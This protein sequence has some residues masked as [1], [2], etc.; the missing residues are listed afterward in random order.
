MSFTE[1]YNW[2]SMEV[3]RASKLAASA[4]LSKAPPLAR[5]SSEVERECLGK[6]NGLACLG[7][8]GR[9]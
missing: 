5:Q 1:R 6:R 3:H 8:D 7:L 9:W 2:R 4:D